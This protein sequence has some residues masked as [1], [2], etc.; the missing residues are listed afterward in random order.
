M[1]G[2]D[3]N[4]LIN[5]LVK[6]P[7]AVLPPNREKFAGAMPPFAVYPDTEIASII[8]YLR[9]NFNTNAP[10]VTAQQVA[11]QRALIQGN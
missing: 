9:A 11:A 3:S 4:L 1:L 2:E 8:N 10:M 7:A 6:G 5:V